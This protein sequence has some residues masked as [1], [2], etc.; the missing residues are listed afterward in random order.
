MNSR[1]AKACD[2]VDVR[3][4]LLA[5]PDRRWRALAAVL[6]LLTIA[7]PAAVRSVTTGLRVAHEYQYVAAVE[8]GSAGVLE[9]E[10]FRVDGDELELTGTVSLDHPAATGPSER[11]VSGVVSVLS[12][13]PADAVPVNVA[14]VVTS[15][16]AV[17]HTEWGVPFPELTAARAVALLVFAA[18]TAAACVSLLRARRRTPFFAMAV[19]ALGAA[20]W[21]VCAAVDGGAAEVFA[22]PGEWL[23][24]FE[25][26]FIGASLIGA[27][28]AGVW[29][30]SF[31]ETPDQ[32]QPSRAPECHS[33]AAPRST[34][35]PGGVSDTGSNVGPVSTV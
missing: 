10:R 34:S 12:P 33:H 31:D 13:V 4:R 17:L 15:D 21:A 19:A 22:G 27:F 35:D 25:Y 14:V 6:L 1:A 16:G 24:R 5:A 29:Y 3:A 26:L 2:A 20:A 18:G 7:A 11:A 28:L 30:C 8:S 9:L 32:Q 23:T